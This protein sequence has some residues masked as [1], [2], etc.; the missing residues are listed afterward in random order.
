LLSRTWA[1]IAVPSL[2]F[3]SKTE[4]WTADLQTLAEGSRKETGMKEKKEWNFEPQ[5]E[6]FKSAQASCK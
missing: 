2:C 5:G 4:H 6:I 3:P 1:R